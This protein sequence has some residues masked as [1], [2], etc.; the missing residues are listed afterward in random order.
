MAA[1]GGAI[2]LIKWLGN[3]PESNPIENVKSWMKMQLASC[4]CT[5]IEELKGEIVRLWTTRMSDSDYLRNLVDS[6]PHRLQEVID[7]GGASTHY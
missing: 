7:G 5:N 2:T 1:T 3:S 6:V 4:N